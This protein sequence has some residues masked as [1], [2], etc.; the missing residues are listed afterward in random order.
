MRR[1][2]VWV[3]FLRVLLVVTLLGAV[4]AS[5]YLLSRATRLA[6]GQAQPGDGICRSVGSFSC[7][8][9]LLSDSARFFG[10]IPS[11]AV[12][13]GVFAGLFLLY[14]I[15]GRGSL[16]ALAFVTAGYLCGAA[17][18][19]YV[20]LFRLRQICVVCLICHVLALVILVL[21]WRLR[22]RQR[23][24]VA[25]RVFL[26]NLAFVGMT[27]V[28]VVLADQLGTVRSSPGFVLARYRSQPLRDIAVRPDDP[29]LGPAS[30]AV[31]CVLFEDFQCP[32]CAEAAKALKRFQAA[33]AGEVRL[34]IKHFPLS[35][36]CNPTVKGYWDGHPQAC[37][38]ARAGEAA[39]ALGR[40]WE[41][42]E[43]VYREQDRLPERPFLEWADRCGLDPDRFRELMDA[44]E[45][46]ER[47]R[48]DVEAGAAAGIEG[49]TPVLFVQGRRF[50]PWWSER[51][52]AL[53]AAQLT[54]A[55][56][57]PAT[58]PAD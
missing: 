44:P 41:Y 33:H 24:V 35:R 16:G 29:T 42:Q 36:D 56:S 39:R 18:F 34:V 26:T 1:L 7:D 58:G 31:T 23:P 51:L 19:V 22:R 37:E 28:G 57:R 2:T 10:A 5:A 27:A 48:Q 15:Q 38:A 30:A 46:V 55:G 54:G 50:H 13:F 17:W 40:F 4:F 25:W 6:T 20:M 3:V 53:T 12:G 47:V 8:S 45:T 9:V 49:E 11:A 43:L 52:L 14:A 21:A 32:T